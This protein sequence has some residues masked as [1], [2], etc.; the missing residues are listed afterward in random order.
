VSQSYFDGGSMG[1]LVVTAIQ[2]GGDRVAFVSG[3]QR[4]SYRQMGQALSQLTQALQARGLQHGDTIATLSVNRPEAFFVSAAGYLLGLRVLWMNPMSSADDH[5]YQLEDASV[6]LLVVDPEH[7][8]VRALSIAAQLPHPPLLMG[9]GTWGDR[10]NL[11][12]EMAAYSALALVS[13]SRSGDDCVLVYTGG[14]TGQPKGVLHSHRVQV[15]M[16]MMEMADFDWPAETRF[17]AMTPITHAAG[18]LIMPVLMR[19]GTVVMHAGFDVKTFCALVQQHRVTCAF[20]VPTMIYVLLDSPVRQDHDLSSLETIMYGA[21][22]MSAARL[23]E[24][25]A[26]LGSIFMQLYGQSEAPM[27]M[28]VLHK[29]EHDPIHNPHRLSSCGT[30]VTGI[31]LKL[32]DDGGREVPPGEVGEI[33]VRG[34][35]VM[36][37][38]LN[39]P[40]ET[41]RAMRHGWLYTGDLARSDADGYLYIVDRSKDMI[42]SG[43]F[44]VFPRE[45]EDVLSAHPAVAAA[46]VVGVPHEKWGEAVHAVVVWRPSQ[47]AEWGDL[48][49]LVRAKKG[50]IH[51]P[52]VF[53]AVDQL[54]TTGLGKVDKKAIRLRLQQGLSSS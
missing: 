49:E 17:L 32:L 9:L 35:L 34:P 25:I 42:I 36:Q 30:P 33:A 19:S 37:G 52:K 38:Y 43:G 24:G 8:G 53:H 29:H 45:V 21:A 15:T 39:K 26:E 22:P 23:R 27:A 7:F 41:A 54:L 1:D 40:E 12:S 20:M 3:G 10:P 2:R 44:N 6:K 14:T 48:A 11:L 51:V 4:V 13:H 28:T 46:A 16:V 50:A 18:A 31:Q 5:R 47:R